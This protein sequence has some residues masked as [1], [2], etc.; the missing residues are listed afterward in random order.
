MRMFRCVAKCDY[1]KESMKQGLHSDPEDFIKELKR[2]GWKNYK[3]GKC[4]CSSCA[5]IDTEIQDKLVQ[6]GMSHHAPQNQVTLPKRG[7][8]MPLLSRKASQRQKAAA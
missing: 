7:F 4:K 8:P 5:A 6:A 1:C 2:E 3:S